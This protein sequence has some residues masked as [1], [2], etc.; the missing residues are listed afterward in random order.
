MHIPR[1]SPFGAARSAALALSAALAISPAWA[2]RAPVVVDGELWL[3]SPPE[4]RKAYLV[5]AAN[6]I[7]LE[8]AYSKKK[9][10]PPPVAGPMAGA[11]LRGLT[12]DQVAN[13][14]TRWYEGNPERRK[15]P[16]LGVIWIDMVAPGAGTK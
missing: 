12:L 15:L 2:Q 16:V 3:R 14:V 6:M 9:G 11:A 13:R 8:T 10:T 4:V 1:F 5:G 7:D